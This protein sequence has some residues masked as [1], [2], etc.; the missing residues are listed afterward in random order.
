MYVLQFQ[1][2]GFN[3]LERQFNYK[4]PYFHTFGSKNNHLKFTNDGPLADYIK[5][6]RLY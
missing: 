2:R 5:H 1:K 4:F 3:E 6:M